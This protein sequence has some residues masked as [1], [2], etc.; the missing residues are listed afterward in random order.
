MLRAALIASLFFCQP[1]LAETLTGRASVID[2][3]TL[4]IS[5]QRIRLHAIDAPE[6]G[7]ACFDA[8]GKPWRCGT[9]AARTMDDLA[10]GKTLACTPRDVDRYGR[11]VAVCFAGKTD[12]GRALVR[13]G[14]AMAYRRY[15][16]DY[17]DAEQ[18]A[19]AARRGMWAG[20]FDWP[21]DWRKTH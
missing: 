11:V 10:G 2:G 21:W 16:E 5:G 20:P 12:V 18:D 17:V 3:D 13:A 7:Q 8:K 6:S 1:A 15:G 14:L 9:M 4:E 19:R